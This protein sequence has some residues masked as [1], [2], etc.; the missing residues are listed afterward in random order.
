M[1]DLP[2]EITLRGIRILKGYLSEGAQ[3]D[4]RDSIREVVRQAPLFQPVTAR[5]RPVGRTR[6]ALATSVS[7]VLGRIVRAKGG[8][9][10]ALATASLALRDTA[11]VVGDRL[12]DLTVS[13]F[14]LVTELAHC[15]W[16]AVDD[17]GNENV[18]ERSAR[19]TELAHAGLFDV[20]VD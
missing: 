4:L 13:A 10:E 5:G 14:E 18:E 20:R 2:E 17:L 3:A 1:S 9:A 15:R 12:V 16:Q 7:V 8:V 19:P 11:L 6:E